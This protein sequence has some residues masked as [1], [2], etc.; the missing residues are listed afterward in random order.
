MRL[1]YRLTAFLIRLIAR[2]LFDCRFS[3]RGTVPGQGSLI[4]AVNH[5][6]KADSFLAGAIIPR[7]VHY[8]AQVEIFTGILGKMVRFYN[9]IPVKRGGVDKEAIKSLLNLLN[10]GEAIMIFPEGGR[11]LPGQKRKSKPGVGLLAIKTKA[12]VVPVRIKG[13]NEFNRGIKG[14]LSLV[15]RKSRVEIKV[16]RPF[17]PL[18]GLEFKE[19]EKELYS[20]ISGMVMERIHQL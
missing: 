15:L 11:V 9:A 14:L 19:S 16:G 6:S 10:S 18:D 1:A 8:A 12:P 5:V 4:V 17:N 20:K 2:I 3:V 13:S 7:E